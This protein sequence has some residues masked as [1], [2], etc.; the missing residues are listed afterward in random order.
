MPDQKKALD[1]LKEIIK[2]KQTHKKVCSQ[3]K[4][5][6]PYTYGN[7]LCDSRK[8]TSAYSPGLKRYPEAW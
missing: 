2:A 8:A 5:N 6:P 4:K 7:D 3:C 1:G